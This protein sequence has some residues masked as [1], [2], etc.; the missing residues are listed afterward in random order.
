MVTNNPLDDL[1]TNE[2]DALIISIIKPFFSLC[3]R[4]PSISYEDL[5][6]EAWIGLLTASERY[7]PTKAKFTTF[8][9]HYIRG[10]VMTY[11]TSRTKNKSYQLT[12]DPLDMDL[13]SC[14]DTNIEADDI[15]RTIL[16]T[17]SDQ[18]HTDLLHEHFVQD[19]SFR[20]IAR[21]RGVSH[22]IISNRVNKLISVLQKRMW[23]ENA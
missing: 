8:A 20:Q 13:Q 3:R 2:W 5:Q 1:P 16:E 17:V 18:K 6:Q 15:M 11:I 9:Y 7:D 12:E 10:R 19:K 22:E 23:N 4:D 21:E 14:V